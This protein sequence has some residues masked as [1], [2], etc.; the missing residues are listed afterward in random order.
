MATINHKKI[1]IVSLTL[2]DGTSINDHEQKAQLL[3]TSF[4]QILGVSEFSNMAYDLTSLLD[5]HDLDHLATDFSQQEI[6]GVIK[7]L[8]NSHAP[9][10]DGF[11]GLFIKRCWNIIQN[12]FVKL[13]MQFSNNNIDLRSIN[14]SIITLIPK[15]ENPESVD[16]YRPISLLNYSLKC[17]TKILSIRLQN[18]IIDL[19]HPNQYGFIKGRTIQDCLAWAFQFLHICH[20]S[21]KEIIILK[22]DFEKAF[23]K[24]EHPSIIEILKYKGFPT[25]S[26]NWIHNILSSGTSSILLNGI[27]GKSFDYKRGVRQ[28]DPLSPLLFVLAGDLL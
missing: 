7:N 19:I 17:I 26:I 13:L 15:K 2:P 5:Q 18:V 12:D 11:N 16:D 1:F 28:G 25:K 23:D 6:E 4:K 22:I 27:L 20:K 14:S 10:P 9:G 21:K 24:I 8:P 3:L